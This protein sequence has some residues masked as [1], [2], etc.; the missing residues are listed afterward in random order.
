MNKKR[1]VHT[2][3]SVISILNQN[4]VGGHEVLKDDKWLL[5][6]PILNELMVNLRDM[7]RRDPKPFTYKDFQAQV[8]HD[9]KTLGFKVGLER[10]KNP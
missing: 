10:L 6:Q 7:L 5:V 9:V 3:S 2:Y 4:Q 1:Q 8:Q